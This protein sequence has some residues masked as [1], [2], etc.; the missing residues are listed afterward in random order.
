MLSGL[1]VANVLTGRWPWAAS[2]SMTPI[3][4]AFCQMMFWGTL[5]FGPLSDGRLSLVCRLA[6]LV[7]AASFVANTLTIWRPLTVDEA[8]AGET[9][10]S[11]PTKSSA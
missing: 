8:N 9:T 10:P 1:Q 2:S 5:H 4:I 6:F 11:T 3:D 7:E